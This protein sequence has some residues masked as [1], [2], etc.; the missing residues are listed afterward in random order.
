MGAMEGGIWPGIA[1]RTLEG[2]LRMILAAIRRNG[3]TVP[4]LLKC[5]NIS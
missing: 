3:R 5:L 2:A 1:Y 4:D